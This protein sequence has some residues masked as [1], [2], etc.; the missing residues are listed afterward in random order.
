MSWLFEEYP[1]DSKPVEKPKAPKKKAAEKAPSKA[2][3]KRKLVD[4]ASSVTAGKA[5]DQIDPQALKAEK[6]QSAEDGKIVPLINYVSDD[7]G[8]V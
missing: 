1:E 5:F 7:D 2:E 3:G 8:S 6:K 4:I